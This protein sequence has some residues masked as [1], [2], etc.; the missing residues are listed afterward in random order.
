MKKAEIELVFVLDRSGSMAGLEEDTIGGY[1]TFLKNMEKEKDVR[2]TTILFDHLVETLY[3]GVDIGAAKLDG[4]QYFVRGST[5]LLDAIGRTI[6]TVDRRHLVAGAE[7]NPAK[8]IFVITTDGMENASREYSY[9]L[10]EKMISRQRKA[11]GWEFV[12]LGANID[13]QAESMKMGI[14]P[15]YA[16]SFASTK[17]GTRNAY[18]EACCC[19]Q[20]I[21]QKPIVTKKVA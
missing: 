13:V 11:F 8:T 6:Q 10:I 17:K 15:A 4:N 21:L 2:V 18:V 3:D 7:G 14:D 20:E 5:A 1:N 9:D 12:F 19:A 16:K